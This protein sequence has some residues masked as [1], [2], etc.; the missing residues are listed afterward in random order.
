[1]KPFIV[2]CVFLLAHALATAAV[3]NSGDW[4]INDD[5]GHGAGTAFSLPVMASTQASVASVAIPA[6]VISADI[7]E[8]A[9]G[10]AKAA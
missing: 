10:E 3:S 5:P 4:F 7:C 2:S 8:S 1:M 6:A 9:W